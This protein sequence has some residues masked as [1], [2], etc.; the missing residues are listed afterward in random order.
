MREEKGEREGG[1]RGFV[2][3]LTITLIK[4][5]YFMQEKKEGASNEE[6]RYCCGKWV[7]RRVKGGGK[8]KNLQHYNA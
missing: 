1:G 2:Q 8:R 3:A 6:I 5:L 4:L 7:G